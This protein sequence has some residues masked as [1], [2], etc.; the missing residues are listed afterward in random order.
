VSESLRREIIDERVR[1]DARM[2]KCSM[3]LI[4]LEADLRFRILISAQRMRRS[5]EVAARVLA[6]TSVDLATLHVLLHAR[7]ENLFP[8]ALARRLGVSRSMATIIVRRLGALGF[9]EV[10]RDHWCGGKSVHLTQAGYEAY[11]LACDLVSDATLTRE[12]ALSL[13]PLL[14]RI[15]RPLTVPAPR[16]R[17]RYPP[18]REKLPEDIQ[19]PTVRDASGG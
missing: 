18:E 8:A 5:L 6:L 16:T 3:T 19:P 10:A 11:A 4:D 9:A 15:E 14:D 17:A 12:E 7:D 13:Y 2:A 1:H